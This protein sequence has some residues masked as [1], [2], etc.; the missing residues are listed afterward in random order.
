MIYRS[1]IICFMNCSTDPPAF[2]EP[3][4]PVDFSGVHPVLQSVTTLV[5]CCQQSAETLLQLLDTFPYEFYRRLSRLPQP[6][7]TQF[8]VAC[9]DNSEIPV[10]LLGRF[11]SLFRLQ[12]LSFDFCG[13]LFEKRCRALPEFCGLFEGLLCNVESKQATRAEFLAASYDHLFDDP[14]LRFAN[15][16]L[17]SVV[18][19]VDKNFAL[20]IHLFPECITLSFLLEVEFSPV[21]KLVKIMKRL[22]ETEI[23]SRFRNQIDLMQL[24]HVGDDWNRLLKESAPSLIPFHEITAELLE[25]VPWFGTFMSIEAASWQTDLDFLRAVVVFKKLLKNRRLLQIGSE[26]AVDVFSSIFLDGFLSDFTTT[27]QVVKKLHR[28]ADLPEIL[29]PFVDRAYVRFKCVKR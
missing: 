13:V 9:S 10:R 23:V 21:Q 5:Q 24:C 25:A 27:F 17:R 19:F 26:I 11:I 22:P 14:I 3:P 6:A 8:L 2:V 12:D 4:V 7:A 1:S 15:T 16:C 29:Q 28:I 18:H 20:T